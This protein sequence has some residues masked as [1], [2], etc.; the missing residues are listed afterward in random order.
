MIRPPRI[1]VTSISAL[2]LAALNLAAAAA[3]PAI[4]IA[5]STSTWRKGEKPADVQSLVLDSLKQAGVTVQPKAGLTLEVDYAE[6]EGPAYELPGT[7]RRDSLPGTKIEFSADLTPEDGIPILTLNFVGKPPEFID[8]D[9]YAFAIGEFK[10]AP[11][12]RD[13]GQAVRATLGSREAL[14]RLLP[15][16]LDPEMHRVIDTLVARQKFTPQAAAER[17][18]LALGRED[19]SELRTLKTDAV[20]P[21]LAYLGTVEGAHRQAQAAA[22]LADLGDPRVAGPLSDA[23]FAAAADSAN[24][25]EDVIAII[26]AAGRAGTPQTIAPLK[27]ISDGNPDD[28]GRFGVVPDPEVRAAAKKAVEAIAARQPK[29]Q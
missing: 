4:A 18:W 1:G 27:R 28:F 16:I 9:P 19:F 3:E 17:A 24:S 22:V 2:L 21:L 23:A 8:G 29:G 26:G 10:H 6:L 13:L 7:R 15:D 20:E 25:D 5:A 14:V 11:A 12:V